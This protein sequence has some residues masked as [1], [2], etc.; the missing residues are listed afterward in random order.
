MYTLSSSPDR[1]LV[2]GN[3]IAHSLSPKI[4]RLFA[5]QTD[6]S[7][8]YQACRLPPEDFPGH[9]RRLVERQRLSGLNVTVPFKEAAYHWVDT[10]SPRARLAGAV[11]T[12][13]VTAGGL[14]GDNTDGVGM[15]RDMTV[16]QG[17]ALAGCRLLVL[18]AG[19]AVR[20]VLGPLLDTAPAAVTIANRTPEKA[21]RLVKRFAHRGEVEGLGYDRLAGRRFDL[22]INGTSAGLQGQA[23]PLPAQIVRRGVMVYDMLYAAT[24][25]P[26]L[27]WARAHGAE[28]LAD[29]LGM[30]VEQAA[31]AFWL[32]RG[33]RPD[34]RAVIRALRPAAARTD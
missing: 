25:T 16:N 15:V 18:G 3:P 10:L 9:A 12:V 5:A 17:I 7:L 34:S 8:T 28:R 1:Y 20:G 2:V 14:H 33:V 13:S 29:G 27:R 31:E 23:V 24:D 30:L 26:L 19:G 32:W 22:I 4:H 6:Q 21:E 11:N